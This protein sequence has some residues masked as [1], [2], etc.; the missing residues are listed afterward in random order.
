MSV[1]QPR[2]DFYCNTSTGR[3]SAAMT[4]EGLYILKMVQHGRYEIKARIS[5]SKGLRVFCTEIPNALVV[6]RP[7]SNPP[8]I[9]RRWAKCQTH[10][11]GSAH[12][13]VRSQCI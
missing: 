9:S 11:N 13:V 6:G 1:H 4:K 5:E 7:I 2:K 10:G 12:V 3:H 8:S